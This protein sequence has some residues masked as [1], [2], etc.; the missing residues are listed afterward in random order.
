MVTNIIF[1]GFDSL[2]R[3]LFLAMV[4]I[5]LEL[6]ASWMAMIAP[7]FTYSEFSVFTD[8]HMLFSVFPIL[9]S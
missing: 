6:T 3:C 2:E 1:Y 7:E 5:K 4:K 8:L 9:D